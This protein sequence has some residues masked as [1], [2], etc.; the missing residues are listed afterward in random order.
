MSSTPTPN[1]TLPTHTFVYVLTDTT[2]DIKTPRGHDS[3]NRCR[4]G[5]RDN[6]T[7]SFPCPRT[8]CV[9]SGVDKKNECQQSAL[10]KNIQV[11]AYIRIIHRGRRAICPRLRQ[12]CRQTLALPQQ[13]LHPHCSSELQCAC[14]AGG[15]R[16]LHL[17]CQSRRRTRSPNS[18]CAAP[19]RAR[20]RRPQ[21]IWRA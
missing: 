21:C 3:T 5:A 10:T 1:T 13:T 8:E 17:V 7:A 14:T 15:M 19:G 18:C 4:E 6:Q 20:T 12:T 11:R 16:R 2:Q 9:R